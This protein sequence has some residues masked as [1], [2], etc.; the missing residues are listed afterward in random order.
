MN[1]PLWSAD[2]QVNTLHDG[3]EQLIAPVSSFHL[4]S[5]SHCHCAN[6][7]GPVDVRVFLYVLL[8]ENWSESQLL[9]SVS[10]QI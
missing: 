4:P 3:R 2:V 7:A 6:T 5:T 1:G 10:P 9:F 8:K